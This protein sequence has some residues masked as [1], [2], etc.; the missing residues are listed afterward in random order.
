MTE[1]RIEIKRPHQPTCFPRGRCKRDPD[2]SRARRRSPSGLQ[3]QVPVPA[4]APAVS[5]NKVSLIFV[6]YRWSADC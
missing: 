2:R 5:C 3:D 6:F 4:T 1:D